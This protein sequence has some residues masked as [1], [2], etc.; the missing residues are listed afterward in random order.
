M[1]APSFSGLA[2]RRIGWP[3][4]ANAA[5]GHQLCRLRQQ[6]QPPSQQQPSQSQ[7]S[8]L[9]ISGLRAGLDAYIDT[10]LYRHLS[11]HDGSI[12]PVTRPLTDSALLSAI[13]DPTRL[14][15]LRQLTDTG[16]CCACDIAD[17]C[18]VSQPTVSHHLRVLRESGWLDAERRGTWIWYSHPARGPR[19]LSAH[20]RQPQ[21]FE[22]SR[23][24]V[25]APASA[26]ARRLAA[27]AARVDRPASDDGAGTRG[28]EGV[29]EVD[30]RAGMVG[31]DGDRFAQLWSR[32]AGREADHAVVVEDTFDA[33]PPGRPAASRNPPGT[34]ADPW[35]ATWR[36][37]R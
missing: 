34:P 3:A 30:H 4:T 2:N 37:R 33:F 13:A 28:N 27:A 32:R 9:N 7:R 1:V 23:A 10:H 5:A 20:R 35:S 26:T 14:R 25:A 6:Q 17:N 18:P 22:R 8:G 19:A 11:I 15:I 12:W 36:R 21:P 16:A 24:R 31:H 29:V